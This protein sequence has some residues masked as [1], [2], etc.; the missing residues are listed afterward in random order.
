MRRNPVAILGA[1]NLA[2]EAALLAVDRAAG[3]WPYVAAVPEATAASVAALSTYEPRISVPAGSLL[4]AISGVSAEAAGFTVQVTDQATRKP[5][6]SQPAA[7][8]NASGGAGIAWTDC[9]GVAQAATSPLHVLP[10]PMLV[11]APGIVAVQIVNL[12]NVANTLQLC[13]HFSIPTGQGAPNGY[14]SILS[15]ELALA[16]RAIRTPGISSPIT[17]GSGMN[18]PGGGTSSFNNEDLIA[19]PFDI[20]NIGDNTIIGA[21]AAGRITIY[22][23]DLWNVAQQTIEL[24]DGPALLRGPLVNFPA[25]TGLALLNQGKYHYRLSPGRPFIITLSAGTQCTGLIYYR[26]E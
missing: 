24:K 7:I 9:Y 2:A 19:A 25:Q 17:P 15:A 21:N 6:F 8:G 18:Q 13:L 10:Q 20:A 3:Y 23:L 14:N 26:M 12:A 4:W 1:Y 5:L 22:Q 16:A 11:L